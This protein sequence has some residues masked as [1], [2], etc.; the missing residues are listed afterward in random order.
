MGEIKPFAV[1]DFSKNLEDFIK[2]FSINKAFALLS[3]FN[4]FRSISI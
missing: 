2:V 4:S 1:N 3:V